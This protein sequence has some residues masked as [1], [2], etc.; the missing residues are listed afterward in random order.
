[1]TYR[2]LTTLQQQI[3]LLVIEDGLSA[4]QAA[5]RLDRTEHVVNTQLTCAT[6]RLK[7]Y[8]QWIL[9]R[10]DRQSNPDQLNLFT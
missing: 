9:S 3:W 10:R 8:A 5:K 2:H 7:A 6:N 1:M 4:S